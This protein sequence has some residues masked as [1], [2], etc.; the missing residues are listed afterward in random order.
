MPWG[1]DFIRGNCPDYLTIGELFGGNYPRVNVW[2][3]LSWGN[4][5]GSIVQEAVIQEG[6]VIEPL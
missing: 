4:F 5:I 1:G 2:G 3:K 6:I